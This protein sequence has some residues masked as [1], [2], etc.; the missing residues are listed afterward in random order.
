[1]IIKN[2]LI[3]RKFSYIIG[4]S[5]LFHYFWKYKILKI[6]QGFILDKNV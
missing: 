4:V 1:M 2:N 3:K 5:Q 6:F